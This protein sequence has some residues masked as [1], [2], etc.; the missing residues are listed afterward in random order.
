MPLPLR[1]SLRAI[2]ALICCAWTGAPACAASQTAAVSANVV[3]PLVIKWLQDLDFGTITLDPGTWS[4]TA[5]TLSRTGARTCGAN[6]TCT[7]ATT[8]AQYN[9]QGSNNQTVRIS[10]PNVTLV[11]QDDASN[12]LTLVTDAPASIVLTSSGVPGVDFAIGG[13]IT[14][15]PTTAAGIYRGTFNVTVDY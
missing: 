4:N 3:K 10:A 9:V 2:A 6:L 11:N 12:T 14:L 5:V 8:A 15:T 13:T 1:S 7:G